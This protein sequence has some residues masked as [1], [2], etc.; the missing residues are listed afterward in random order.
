MAGE[1][2]CCCFVAIAAFSLLIYASISSRVIVGE[3]SVEEKG[4]AATGCELPSVVDE[5]TCSALLLI[6]YAIT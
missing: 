2:A 1:D 4:V 3:F 6:I 5:V